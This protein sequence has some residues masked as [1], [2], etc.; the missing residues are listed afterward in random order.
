MLR[1]I[2]V[3]IILSAGLGALLY[4][5]PWREN[6]VKNPRIIDRLPT[7]DF[8]GTMNPLELVKE[9][10]G[11]INYNKIKY[12]QFISYDF[13]LSQSRSLGINLQ[14]PVFLFGFENGNWGCLIDLND[15]SKIES[16]LS[17]LTTLFNLKKKNINGL[18]YLYFKEEKLSIFHEGNYL[19]LY[20]GSDFSR[21]LTEVHNS[22]YGDV[23]SEWS[24]F[25]SDENFKNE[26]LVI[27]SNWKKLKQFGIEKAMFA[28]DNDSTNF[29]LKTYF[30]KI[31]PFYVSPKSGPSIINSKKKLGNYANIHLNIDDFKKHP[32]DVL[33]VEISK[34]MRK[35]G[36]PF[37]EFI[38]TWQGDI[39]FHEG[40][41]TT[42]KEIFKETVLDEEFNPILVEKE[43]TVVVPAYTSLITINN[44]FNRLYSKLKSKGLVTEESEKIRFLVSPPLVKK[45]KK[46]QL[47]LFSGATPIVKS[48]NQNEIQ[49]NYK[50]TKF[51][52]LLQKIQGNELYGNLN[53]S[54]RKIAKQSITILR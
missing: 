49:W 16:G 51:K 53:F 14:N 44:N 11:L 35:Y 47:I 8:I 50:G 21:I 54:V 33:Y 6:E 36:F 20:S 34:L 38:K 13:L 27:F 12:R 26:S 39:S 10:S 48:V 3:I 41:N 43:R 37:D 46:N 18:S 30:K 31:S 17:Q 4:L 52:F 1:K 45:V 40:G 24:S 23:K 7:A 5:K 42:A 19:L 32:E 25:L 28:H 2:I 9:M 22:K 15:D 29:N